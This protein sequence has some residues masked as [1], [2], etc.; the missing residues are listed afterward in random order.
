MKVSL[1]IALCV[2]GLLQDSLGQTLTTWFLGALLG[3]S[4]LASRAPTAEPEDAA[5]VEASAGD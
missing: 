1:L 4:M 2:S 3:A 5:V